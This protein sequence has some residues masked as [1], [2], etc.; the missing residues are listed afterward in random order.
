MPWGGAAGVDFIKVI[1]K[2][3]LDLNFLL[4]FFC[5]GRTP[6]NGAVSGV[7]QLNVGTAYLLGLGVSCIS[8]TAIKYVEVDSCELKIKGSAAW[9]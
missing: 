5:T 6:A 9:G 3:I 1:I 7:H 4:F 2:V 8:G